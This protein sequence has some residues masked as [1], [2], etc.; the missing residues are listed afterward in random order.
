M[1]DTFAGD[2][3]RRFCQVIKPV[4]SFAERTIG[5]GS[6]GPYGSRDTKN[7]AALAY[8]SNGQLMTE[9]QKSPLF[10]F[11]VKGLATS[12][13]TAFAYAGDMR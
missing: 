2:E 13:P 11:V 10:L 3:R 12:R 8:G 4:E 6:Y 9:A 7:Q 5:L 1:V